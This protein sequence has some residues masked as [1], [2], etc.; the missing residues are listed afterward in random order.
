M[1]P[2]VHSMFSDCVPKPLKLQFTNGGLEPHLVIK[3]LSAKACAITLQNPTLCRL[4]FMSHWD[5]IVAS[6]RTDYVMSTGQCNNNYN[7]LW[8]VRKWQISSRN[9]KRRFSEG[10]AGAEPECEMGTAYKLEDGKIP[11]LALS[12]L[13][14][15]TI[16]I[17]YLHSVLSMH[18]MTGL[19]IML[20]Q[21]GLSSLEET[22]FPEC[23]LST[24]SYLAPNPKFY[25]FII[26]PGIYKA[27]LILRQYFHQGYNSF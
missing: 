27:D 4:P 25:P 17:W 19:A 16:Y 15:H 8:H 5:T 13:E 24:P 12:N 14:V 21:F 9:L 23:S 2:S 20:L 6:V 1:V 11:D 7:W 10:R 3:I 22:F 26:W 18:P